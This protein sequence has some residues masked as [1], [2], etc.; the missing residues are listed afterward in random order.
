VTTAVDSSVLLDVLGADPRFGEKSREAL[1]AA[2]DR[3]ALVAS[4]VVW[5]EVRAHFPSDEA[6]EAIL[7]LLGIRFEPL[8]R[9]AALTAGRLWRESRH[10][11]R[12]A[13][14]RVVADFLIGAH[15]LVQADVLLTRDR[16]FYQ[17]Y[18]RGLRVIDPTSA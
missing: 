8:S 4:D 6:C 9:E 14:A 12:G 18:F 13:G 5:A 1:R 17:R 3:G 15:A 11:A 16:G 10:G 7:G 2:Y